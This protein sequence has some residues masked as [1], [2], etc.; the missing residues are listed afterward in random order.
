MC[1][2]LRWNLRR[3]GTNH[4]AIL[5]A[6]KAW[7]APLKLHRCEQLK[8]VILSRAQSK[9]L[10]FSS[11]TSPLSHK[12]AHARTHTGTHPHPP[13]ITSIQY[14]P[15]L[16]GAFAVRSMGTPEGLKQG[17]AAPTYRPSILPSRKAGVVASPDGR[18]RPTRDATV[19][20]ILHRL[21]TD[22]RTLEVGTIP[23]HTVGTK[24]YYY[25]WISRNSV[26]RDR[27][28]GPAC[29]HTGRIW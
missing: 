9:L 18:L 20:E 11:P 7:L 17:L 23:T 5:R 2:Q 16:Q 12:H 22:Q 19:K 14:P 29:T 24:C 21:V 8:Y 13:C 28:P 27:I 4:S 3:W 1:R 25:R 26:Y 6:T 15:G 10:L